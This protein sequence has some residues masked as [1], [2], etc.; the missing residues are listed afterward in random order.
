M[1]HLLYARFWVKALN[2]AKLLPFREP[3][4][5]L[6]NQGIILAEDGTKMS[7]SK[8]NVVNPDDVV[9]VHGADA[10]RLFEMFLGP[11]EQEKNW[12]TRGIAGL[13]RFLDRVWRLQF[14]E[15]T[16][17]APTGTLRTAVEKTTQQVTADVEHLRFNTAI[18]A[19]MQLTNALYEQV[20]A[21]GS[22]GKAIPTAAYERLILLLAPLAPH[23]TE[24]LWSRLGH[25]TSIHA[26]P[27]PAFD[28]KALATDTANVVIQVNGKYRGR[29]SVPLGA[30]EGAVAT[31]ALKLEAVT[32]ALS[33]KQPSRRVFVQDKVLN[34]VA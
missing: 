1:L 6:R 25:K 28:Q 20:G 31:A 30:P 29:V 17:T 4:M 23:I 8:G 13:D 27:W 10:L 2:D 3:F 16:T 7:K 19:L 34:L 21:S 32:R 14:V 15:R 9:K 18:S 33:G 12:S 26:E 11:L 22:G 24:E 5:T